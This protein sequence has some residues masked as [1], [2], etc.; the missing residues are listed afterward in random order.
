MDSFRK[1]TVFAAIVAALFISNETISYQK[2][3][4]YEVS[5]TLENFINPN[6]EF[7]YTKNQFAKKIL[8]YCLRNDIT[9]TDSISLL[10]A[11]SCLESGYG[12]S[13][14]A[15][16]SNNIYGITCGSKWLGKRTTRR[17]VE[18]GKT[19]NLDFRV[20]RSEYD[21]FLDRLKL[22]TPLIKYS[23]KRSKYVKQLLKFANRI[24]QNIKITRVI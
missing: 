7:S 1:I 12:L 2:R 17:S 16:Q 9:N 21:S 11:Q 14:L 15:I 23:T 6:V 10:I 4:N 18:L 8:L 3:Q 24:K 22:K 20:Y 13:D 5:I 19:V